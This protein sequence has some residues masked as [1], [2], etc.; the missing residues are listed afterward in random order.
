MTLK[1]NKVEKFLKS[2]VESVSNV[3]H[4]RNIEIF[5]LKESINTP[6]FEDEKKIANCQVGDFVLIVGDEVWIQNAYDGS[7]GQ[8]SQAIYSAEFVRINPILFV[9]A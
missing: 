4:R 2:A 5:K 6:L 8:F 3:D 1:N 7:R 9:K